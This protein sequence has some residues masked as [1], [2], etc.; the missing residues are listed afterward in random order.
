MHPR[1]VKRSH[2]ARLEDLPN[3][4]PAMAADFRLLGIGTPEDLGGK[5]AFA[6]YAELCARTG[7]R[8]DPRVIDVFLSVT[9]FIA[10]GE[11]LPWWHFTAER[12]RRLRSHRAPR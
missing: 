9:S 11:P 10:G 1:K 3:I 7:M 12:K 4:G 6:L 2:L 8:H 5:D